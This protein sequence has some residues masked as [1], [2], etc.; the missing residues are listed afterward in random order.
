M[1]K[2]AKMR[3]QKWR[4][5]KTHVDDDWF[6]QYLFRIYQHTYWCVL[7]IQQ[8][9]KGHIHLM[10]N[11]IIST[12]F[13]CV[14]CGYFLSYKIPSLALGSSWNNVNLHLSSWSLFLLF[15]YY[16]SLTV[17]SIEKIFYGNFFV[18]I[19]PMIDQDYIVSI[20]S[21]CSVVFVLR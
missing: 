7:W 4:N 17:F 20:S 9:N 10:K 11:S 2:K 1:K 15:I 13:V 18:A 3:E 21:W 19:L 12:Q 14:V 6:L 16:F 8:H 5:K